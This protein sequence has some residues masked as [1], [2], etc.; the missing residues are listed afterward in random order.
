MFNEP[1]I[2]I[3]LGTRPEII[4]LAPVIQELKRRNVP[5]FVIHTGQHY[6]ENMDG[7]FWRILKL[8][9][10]QYQLQ[11]REVT[12]ARQTSE[13]L[14]QVDEILQREQPQWILVQGDTNST[15]A[16]ALAASKHN[17]IK[18]A[19]LEAGLRSFDRQMPE[20]INRLIVDR[21]SDL[22]LTPTQESTEF[23]M[24]E[25]FSPHLVHQVGNTVEDVLRD[26]IPIAVEQS[27]IMRRLD[28]DLQSYLLV[29]IHR[30]ENT[31]NKTR[32]LPILNSL[33]S[34]ASLHQL[35]V[36]FPIHPRTRQCLAQWGYE[37]PTF[38]KMIDP[39]DYYDFLVLEKNARLVAT[40]S[41]GVQ[42]ETCIL[43]VPCITLR[44]NT[45]R[46]ETL[47]LGSNILVGVDAAKIFH[48]VELQLNKQA[49]I[50]SVASTGPYGGGLAS[51][52]VVDLL[53]S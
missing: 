37:V 36:V 17:D 19:H 28:L 10:P 49:W 13:M 52:K 24:R 35:E 11:I 18:V 46:P 20:E 4:K 27:D 8:A 22:L 45:E 5:H 12:H 25:G 15:L 2:G 31:L 1:K 44:E 39:V 43:G 53:V 23:L 50:R 34:S 48:A 3:V 29:T 14:R 41:G 7:V 30:Q 33:F 32:L 51:Q 9:P 16:G 21:I 47:R 40:D 6:S 38:V 42:E 26:N